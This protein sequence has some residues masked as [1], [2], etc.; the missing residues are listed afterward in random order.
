MFKAVDGV[1]LQI[2][3]CRIN[4]AVRCRFRQLGICRVPAGTSLQPRLSRLKAADFAMN[5]LQA[6]SVRFCGVRLHFPEQTQHFFGIREIRHRAGIRIRFAGFRCHYPHRFVSRPLH[7]AAGERIAVQEAH[8]IPHCARS[9]FRN[10]HHLQRCCFD[11]IALILAGKIRFGRIIIHR[12]KD[13]RVRTDADKIAETYRR[14]RF[15]D[16]FR[17][18]DFRMYR[19]I[20]RFC[21]IRLLRS[22]AFIRFGQI[23]FLVRRVLRRCVCGRFCF[24][25]CFFRATAIDH[26]QSLLTDVS[27]SVAGWHIGNARHIRIRQIAGIQR[28]CRYKAADGL[29]LRIQKPD[30]HGLMT[31]EKRRRQQNGRIIS[32]GINNALLRFCAGVHV[33]CPH[34]PDVDIPMFF[35]RRL[36]RM[37]VVRRTFLLRIGEHF[38]MG[39]LIRRIGCGFVRRFLHGWKRLF[40]CRKHNDFRSCD[41]RGRGCFF[42][43]RT[44]RNAVQHQCRR[45]HQ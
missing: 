19:S 24:I 15:V 22:A 39:R 5:V 20:R 42:C 44:E 43:C 9:I 25:G 40:F 8:L 35:N 13:A 31:A 18:A 32:R 27:H 14:H 10:G 36:Q 2:V 21:A 7:L 4:R 38:V 1:A 30:L 12:R 29:L 26:E 33:D 34:R 17:A 16:F 3:R 23:R 11:E 41:V 6:E 28:R 45:Q 37:T